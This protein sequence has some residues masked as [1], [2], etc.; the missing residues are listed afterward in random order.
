[1]K[2]QFSTEGVA[3]IEYGYLGRS[4]EVKRILDNIAEKVDLGYED[5]SIMDINGNKIGQWSL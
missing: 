1:M 3:F 4:E 5:G 2:I